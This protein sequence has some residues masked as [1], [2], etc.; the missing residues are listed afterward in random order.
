[1]AID[2]NKSVF[3]KKPYF[4][5]FTAL[6]SFQYSHSF[7][8]FL[9]KKHDNSEHIVSQCFISTKTLHNQLKNRFYEK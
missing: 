8:F 7:I 1:M 6:I 4:P 9:L 5:I 2:I 3:L